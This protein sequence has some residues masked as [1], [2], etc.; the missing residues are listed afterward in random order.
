MRTGQGF[1]I[2]FSITSRI[3]LEKTSS[4]IEQIIRVKDC[5]DVPIVIKKLFLFFIFIFY[6]LFFIFYFL[7]FIFYFFLDF[8]WKQSRFGR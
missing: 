8:G 4:F 3:S 6:F 7:F 2:V 1:L 5:D